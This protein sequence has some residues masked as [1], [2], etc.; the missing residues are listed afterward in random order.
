[1]RLLHAL[2][3]LLDRCARF[4]R[5]LLIAAS[6]CAASAGIVLALGLPRAHTLIVYAAVAFATVGVILALPSALRTS[7]LGD[8][9]L[10]SDRTP[11][12]ET[13]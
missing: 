6:A 7:P 9:P 4:G 2:L 12:E 10:T 11:V 3:A 5:W 13:P 8:S 1:M